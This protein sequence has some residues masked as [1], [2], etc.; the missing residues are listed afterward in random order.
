MRLWPALSVCVPVAL[1]LGPD[2][3]A[4]RDLSIDASWTDPRP[5]ELVTVL[6]HADGTI[7]ATR[8]DPVD[9]TTTTLAL[10]LTDLP[11]QAATVQSALID[12]A[13]IHAQSAVLRIDGARDGRLGVELSALLALSLR[14]AFDCGTETGIVTLTEGV[15]QVTIA[16]AGTRAPEVLRPAPDLPGTWQSESRLV[17][18][19]DGARLVL[20][21]PD[22][23]PQVC[24]A[25]PVPPVLPVVAQGMTGEWQIDLAADAARITLPEGTLAEGTP[26]AP[27]GAGRTEDGAILFRSAQFTLRLTPGLCE[28]PGD[29]TPYPMA[30]TL[31]QEDGTALP[32]GCAGSPFDLL[33]GQEWQ[34]TSLLGLPVAQAMTLGFASGQVAGRGS[35]NRYQASVTF[36]G[37]RMALRDLGTTRVGCATAL[38]NLELRFLDALEAAT[39][40]ALG[41]DGTLIL[42][43][44]PMPILTA[45]RQP[46]KP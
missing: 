46:A 6:R 18:A 44:G 10:D 24:A 37:G 27:V 32:S 19:R 21:L 25:L 4:A 20:T 8:R 15:E 35:C 45:Q 43:A 22:T 33:T 9:A 26:V 41:N 7:L 1:A 38:Q 28:R 29:R 2:P 16:L 42:R 5:A 30:A 39:G 14:G 11:R 17:A 23:A 13:Q 3:A 34:V 31:E 12:A 40:F 36:E